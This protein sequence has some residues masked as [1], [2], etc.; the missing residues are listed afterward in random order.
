MD[1]HD[2]ELLDKQL[3]ATYPSPPQPGIIVVTILA[4][5]LGGMIMGG[6][7]S[8]QTT[9]TTAANRIALAFLDVGT[10]ITRN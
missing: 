2:Q 5:F 7:L 1:Q 6:L 10:P 8:G 3:R 4:I 9:S